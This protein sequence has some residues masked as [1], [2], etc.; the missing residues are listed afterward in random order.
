[1]TVPDPG[2]PVVVGVDGSENARAAA[3][4]AAAEARRRS[5]P[6]ELVSALPRAFFGTV[7][8]A[9]EP[10]LFSAVNQRVSEVLRSVAAEVTDAVGEGPV[11]WSVVEG[12]P[13][14]VLREASA[15]AQLVVLGSRGVGGV[16]GCSRGPPPAPSSPRPTAPSSSSPTTSPPR[17]ASDGPSS[18]ASRVGPVTTRSSPSPSRRPRP[19]APT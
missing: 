1:M 6:L 14:D 3:H 4:L 7:T 13:A 9:P 15:R 11:S 16:P 18:W 17:S 12:A 5:A 19:A 10:G 2:R 8:V